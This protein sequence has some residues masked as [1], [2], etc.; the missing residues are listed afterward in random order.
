MIVAVVLAAIAASSDH[1]CGSAT[2]VSN[3]YV[4]RAVFGWL[5]CRNPRR[6]RTD[7]PLNRFAAMGGGR[8]RR[9]PS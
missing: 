5:L 2:N 4:D 7:I 9:I 6:D 3:A 8:K 1:I